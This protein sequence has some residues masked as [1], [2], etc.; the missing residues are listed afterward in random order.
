MVEIACMHGIKSMGVPVGAGAKSG[1]T[2]SAPRNDAVSSRSNVDNLAVFLVCAMYPPG[3]QGLDTMGSL[4]VLIGALENYFHPSNHGSWT[5]ILVQFLH[6]LTSEFLKRCLYEA[7]E[8]CAIPQE[9]RITQEMKTAFVGILERCAFLAVFGRDNASVTSAQFSLRNLAWISPDVIFPQLLDHAY[10]ALEGVQAH[11]TQ[12]CIGALSILAQ[13]LVHRLH[14][15]DGAQHILPL[16]MMVLPGIDIN[17]P[18]KTVVSL[19]FIER[20]GM[21]VPFGD[22]FGVFIVGFLDRIFKM[23]ENL[24][25]EH[26]TTRSKRGGSE[27]VVMKTA[28]YTASIV[29]MNASVGVLKIAVRRVK[30]FV[31]SNVIPGATKCIGSLVSCCV[32]HEPRIALDAFMNVACDAIVEEL[33]GGGSGEASGVPSVFEK[34]SRYAFGFA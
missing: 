22:E 14:Y 31:E 32:S 16:C 5:S 10:G 18:S 25:L 24:P 2:Q 1:A 26:G 29:L 30:E 21:L 33:E 27:V 3:V 8:I 20:V 23:M 13:P 19:R 7:S 15:P 11:R 12:S 34:K 6:S 28:I 9:L 17:D 4:G